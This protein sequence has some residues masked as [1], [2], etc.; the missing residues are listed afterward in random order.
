MVPRGPERGSADDAGALPPSLYREE[1]LEGKPSIR[2]GLLLF[3]QS[4]K[5]AMDPVVQQRERVQGR[6]DEGEGERER[7]C[8]R[9]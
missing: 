9:G 2:V 1:E 6:R 8:G 3:T 5:L 7:G 4:L